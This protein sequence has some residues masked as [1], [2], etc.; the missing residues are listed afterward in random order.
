MEGRGVLQDLIPDMGQLE[1]A[2]VSIKG[3]II[4]AEVHGL[5]DGPGNTVCLPTHYGEIVHSD[6]MT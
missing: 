2:C 4:Y 5:L 6:V 1:L 3:W